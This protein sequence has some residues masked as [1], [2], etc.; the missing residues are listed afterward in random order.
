MDT[1]PLFGHTGVEPSMERIS[2]EARSGSKRATVLEQQTWGPRRRKM[3]IKFM[4][5]WESRG[6]LGYP[7]HT[8]WTDVFF[9]GRFS[10]STLQSEY[11]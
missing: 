7:I 2:S 5:I 4:H 8:T 10:T 3:K 9:L 1:N 11:P 6:N